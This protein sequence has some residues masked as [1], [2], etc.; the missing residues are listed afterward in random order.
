MHPLCEDAN[1]LYAERSLFE[2]AAIAYYT[3]VSSIPLCRSERPALLGL[4]ALR[5]HEVGD[6][7]R[8]QAQP[9]CG[10]RDPQ[11]CRVASRAAENDAHGV[12][13]LEERPDLARR[14]TPSARRDRN[15]HLLRENF[16][17]GSSG[18]VPVKSH[19]FDLHMRLLVTCSTSR[20]EAL[21]PH[22][23]GIVTELHQ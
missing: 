21:G 1:V 2:N 17:L 23:C 18:G 10:A 15:R 6:P 12:A 8:I 16:T 22:A 3:M 5:Y 20:P 7:R 4:T 14:P 11:H 9:A 13:V 19:L